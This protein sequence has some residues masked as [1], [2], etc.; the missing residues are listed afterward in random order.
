[1]KTYK[2]LIVILALGAIAILLF[3][4]KPVSPETVAEAP[5]P[6]AGGAYTEGL[7][8]AFSRFNPVLDFYNSVD[9]DVDRLLF[10]SLVRFDHRG[11]PQGDLAQDWGISQDGT[12]Y[13]FSIRPNY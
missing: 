12:V 2:I 4:Q 13:N 5:E 6:V 10:S 9:R 3:S 1:M 7:I 11:L 8:G